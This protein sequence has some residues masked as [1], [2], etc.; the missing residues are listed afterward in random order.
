MGNAFYL[1]WEYPKRF[2]L[3]SDCFVVPK[4]KGDHRKT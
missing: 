2:L 1:F 4:A 3:E